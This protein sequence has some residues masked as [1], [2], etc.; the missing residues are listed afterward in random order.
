MKSFCKHGQDVRERS[1]HK[2]ERER[3]REGGE[4]VSDVATVFG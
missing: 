2:R 1:G 4:S 3:E